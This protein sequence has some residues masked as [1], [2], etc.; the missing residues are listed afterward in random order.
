MEPIRKLRAMHG[1]SLAGR[2]GRARWMYRR[3]EDL[4]RRLS[5]R[6]TA[7][8][9]VSKTAFRKGAYRESERSEMSSMIRIPN[10]EN[11]GGPRWTSAG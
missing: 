4:S 5:T 8:E 11:I 7:A 9:Y 6:H 1:A 2:T 3:A 10:T